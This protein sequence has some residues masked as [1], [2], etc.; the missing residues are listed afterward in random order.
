LQATLVFVSDTNI[1]ID[2]EK[3]GLLDKLFS[4][5]FQYWTTD[6]VANELAQPEP[7]NW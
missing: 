5:P 2:F 6:F 1:W 7:G 3:V 4:L